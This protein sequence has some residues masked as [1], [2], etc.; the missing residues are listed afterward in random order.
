MTLQ[1]CNKKTF[2]AV[3]YLLLMHDS[4]LE[5]ESYSFAVVW[6]ISFLTC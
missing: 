5:G 2:L 1:F 3:I 6:R 4:G